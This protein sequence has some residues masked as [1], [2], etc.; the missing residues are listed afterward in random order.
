MEGTS[1][2]ALLSSSRFLP[3]GFVGFFFACGFLQ[4][5]LRFQN[6][7]YLVMFFCQ[8]KGAFSVAESEGHHGGGTE[9]ERAGDT[10][11]ATE[12]YFC[13]NE[14]GDV[15]EVSSRDVEVVMAKIGMSCDGDGEK[16]K[17][18]LGSDELSVLFE[19]KEPSLE[20]LK[21][22]FDVFDENRDGF[23]DARELQRVLCNL[24]F[25]EALNFH[26]CVGMI[27]A[28]DTDGDNRIDFNEFVIFMENSFC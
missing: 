10:T 16:M 20:E 22:A 8:L 13:H 9:R 26:A 24:G 11:A 25:K 5:V 19:E 4:W 15:P 14:D 3:A 7:H 12:H 23:V 27:R 18:F 17:E 1:H 2:N 6:L 21:E 28:F